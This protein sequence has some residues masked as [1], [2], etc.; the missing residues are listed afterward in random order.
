MYPHQENNRYDVRY[1]VS[2]GVD[3][4]IFLWDIFSGS[5]LHTFCVHGGEITR[6][7]VPPENCNVSLHVL[8]KDSC[9][10][11]RGIHLVCMEERRLY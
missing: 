1:M 8:V 5:L 6:M 11:K 7:V 10:L 3:F 9:Q 4:S 2:G